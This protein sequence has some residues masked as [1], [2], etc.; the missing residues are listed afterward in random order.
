MILSVFTSL[1]VA[2]VDESILGTPYF[3][4]SVTSVMPLTFECA[5]DVHLTSVCALNTHISSECALDTC[6]HVP[7]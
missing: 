6:L 3:T 1:M 4:V 7:N 2:S 5:L